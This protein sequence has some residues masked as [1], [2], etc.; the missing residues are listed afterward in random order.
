MMLYTIG[1]S[2]ILQN[3]SGKGYGD[4]GGD[5]GS[6]ER[7]SSIS[8]INTYIIVGAGY[9]L[10]AHSD[11]LALLNRIELS[12]I[13]GID[14]SECKNLVDR[15]LN[16]IKNAKETYSLLIEVAEITPYNQLVISKLK[17]F[18]YDSYLNEHALNSLIFKD[19]EDYLKNGDIRGV[20]KRIYYDVIEIENLL[21][22]IKDE[23]SLNK[24]P[25]LSNLWKLNEK[26]SDTLIYGGYVA[27]VFF[28]LD[29]NK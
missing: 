25:E 22:S 5:S 28:N 7:R 27:R 9:Y 11:S 21:I 17:S 3:G 8:I 20:H 1:L 2:R 19:V 14:Y 4:D 29:R 18:D 15:A 26:F 16:N 12:E 13:I 24:M 23:I 10:N 6:Q